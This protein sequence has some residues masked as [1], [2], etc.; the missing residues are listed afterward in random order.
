M[1][2][3]ILGYPIKTIKEEWKRDK[4]I[5]KTENNGKDL[6][7]N[8]DTVTIYRERVCT[9]IEKEY[10]VIIYKVILD[11]YSFRLLFIYLG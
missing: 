11:C 6:V 3:I 2:S 9:N 5:I 1:Y 10:L 7:N 8:R 4:I